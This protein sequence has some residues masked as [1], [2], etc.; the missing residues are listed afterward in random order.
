MS[1][2]VR[3]L[4]T[5]VSEAVRAAAAE[6]GP[7][8]AD[9]GPALAALN[10][11]RLRIVLGE[12]LRSAMEEL[13]PDGLSSADAQDLIEHCTEQAGWYPEL[14]PAVLVVVLL[15]AFGAHDPDQQPAWPPA[16]V[17]Q[18]AAVLLVDL[19]AGTGSAGQPV[20]PA[21]LAGQA[22]PAELAGR[23]EALLDRALAELERAETM[24]LP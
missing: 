21:E 5:A 8:L 10:E 15:G 20:G 6:D 23:A 12:M 9:C 13:H 1:G 11:P 19:L 14:D 24:E 3:A 2:P 4:R 18:H 22:D 16:M 7:A 17:A